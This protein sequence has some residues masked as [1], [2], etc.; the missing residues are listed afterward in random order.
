MLWVLKGVR[1]H[2]FVEEK[3]NHVDGV[4]GLVEC[5]KE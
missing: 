1:N 2:I 4:Y 5:V 3:S